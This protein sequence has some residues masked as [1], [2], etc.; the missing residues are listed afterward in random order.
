MLFR[1]INPSNRSG[2]WEIVYHPPLEPCKHP[3]IHP[4]TDDDS[5][6]CNVHADFDMNYL[7]LLPFR[8]ATR[9]I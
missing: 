2:I 1:N 5:L 6:T 3:S 8:T 7:P 4:P 9:N